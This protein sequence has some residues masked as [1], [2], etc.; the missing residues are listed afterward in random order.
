MDLLASLVTGK[1]EHLPR[2]K[3]ANKRIDV[4]FAHIDSQVTF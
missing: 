1:C 2:A 4:S 3:R